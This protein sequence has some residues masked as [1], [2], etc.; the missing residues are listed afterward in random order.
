MPRAKKW[1]W[2]GWEAGSGWGDRGFSERKIRMGIR[3]ET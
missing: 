3:F 2:V 1:E